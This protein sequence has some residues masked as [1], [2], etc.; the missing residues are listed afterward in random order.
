MTGCF[1]S[2][3]VPPGDTIA[4][5]LTHEPWFPSGH[6]GLLLLGDQHTQRI[7]PILAGSGDRDP[8]ECAG[9]SGTGEQRGDISNSQVMCLVFLQRRQESSLV[10]QW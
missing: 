5:L 6:F 9:Y 2:K 10:F 8:K 7:V 3:K 4:V 1:Q